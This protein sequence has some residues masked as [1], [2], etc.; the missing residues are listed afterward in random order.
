MPLYFI[1]KI[2]KSFH[3]IITQSETNRVYF[4]YHT[5]AKNADSA[6]KKARAFLQGRGR[7][8]SRYSLYPVSLTELQNVQAQTIGGKQVFY[9]GGENV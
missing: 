1:R 6:A 5:K 2:M 3:Y 7:N 9:M 8:P 4:L